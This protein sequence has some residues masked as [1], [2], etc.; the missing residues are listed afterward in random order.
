M[1]D[2]FSSACSTN[3]R[4]SPVFRT[5]SCVAKERSIADFFADL[6]ADGTY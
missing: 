1:S 3:A 5:S 6:D 4:P 2:A